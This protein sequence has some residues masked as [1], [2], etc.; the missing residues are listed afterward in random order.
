MC[1]VSIIIPVYNVSKYLEICMNS[2]MSQSLKDIEIICVD[3]GSTDESPKMLDDYAKEDSRISVIHKK[4]SGYGDSVNLGIEKAKGKYIGIVEPD[5][6]VSKD[7][8]KVLYEKASDLDLDLIK[9]NFANFVG[10]ETHQTVNS[11]KVIWRDDLYEKVIRPIDH[12]EIFRGYIINPSGI[13]KKAFLE[14]YEIKHNTTPGASYQDTGF[15]FQVM[16]HAEKAYLVNEEVYYYR[17]DNNQ[18]SI[19]NN[20]KIYCICDEYEYIRKKIFG[21]KQICKEA[22]A[23]FTESMFMGY[24]NTIP[25][26]GVGIK[27]EFIRRFADDF[28]KIQSYGLLDETNLTKEEQESLKRIIVNTEDYIHDLTKAAEYYKEK[29]SGM[30]SAVIYGCGKYGQMVLNN[31]FP[32]ELTRVKG[33]VVSHMEGQPESVQGFK[34]EEITS[35]L[36]LKD[37]I[38]V[39]IG[40]SEQ[41]KVEV[42]KTLKELGFIKIIN[43][44]NEWK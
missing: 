20:S 40:V 4:N 17:Q 34:V 28:K 18:S 39:L 21:E 36:T 16:Y 30:E 25:R 43:L 8:F 42:S 31:L 23:A 1:K 10:D 7:M 9:G 41:Y 19:N 44:W 38:A 3:D 15:W 13:Y 32:E 29:L 37:K 14:K 35:Y 24:F 5:D 33:F 12:N 11:L 2:V 6:Y 27:G 26:L 22:K